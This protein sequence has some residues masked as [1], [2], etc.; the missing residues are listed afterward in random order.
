MSNG[1][2][3]QPR[4]ERNMRKAKKHMVVI[5]K[6]KFKGFYVTMLFISYPDFY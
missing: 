2:T 4:M 3:R 5:L 1:A 6:L